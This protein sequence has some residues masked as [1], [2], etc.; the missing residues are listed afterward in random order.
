MNF[1]TRGPKYSQTDS[2]AVSGNATY[3]TASASGEQT[4]HGDLSVGSEKW[5]FL[6]SLTYNYFGDL[7]MGIH[8]PDSYLRPAYIARRNGEDQL[9]E[10]GE[11][12]VQV[13]TGYDI[14]SFMQKIGFRPSRR[15][16]FDLGL[17]Y[18]ETSDNPRYD[19]LIRPAD[20]EAGL[21]SAEWFYGPQK[22]GMANL[23]ALE[24]S[25]A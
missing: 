25:S 24:N 4:I 10:N 9:V 21:K 1:Y 8:G 17:H 18:S 13:P 14:W 5:A 6:S 15:W 7:R 2:I 16:S 19:R 22:W 23:S 3:R 12:R 20:N 11:P